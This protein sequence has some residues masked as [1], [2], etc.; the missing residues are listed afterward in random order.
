MKRRLLNFVT[1][2]SL[3][4]CVAVGVLWVRSGPVDEG[5]DLVFSRWPAADEATISIVY[6]ASYSGTV[7]LRLNHSQY[8]PAYFRTVSAEEAR[9]MRQSYPPGHVRGQVVGR[10]RFTWPAA[11]PMPGFRGEHFVSNLNP[12]HRCDEWVVAAPAWLPMA[13]LAVMPAL[14]AYRFVKARRGARLGL[15]SNCGYDLRASPDR[16]PECGRPPPPVFRR[17]FTPAG[18]RDLAADERR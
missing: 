9:R 11:G 2:T 6:A 16:C 15:C 4:L 18:Q 14:W 10:S 8:G 13:V 1:V 5:A 17:S 7:S 12:G 3:L